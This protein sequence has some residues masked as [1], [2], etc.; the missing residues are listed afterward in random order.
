MSV[1][2]R[3]VA[4]TG[5]QAVVIVVVKIV[6][7]AGLRVGQIGKNRPLAGFEHLGFEPRPETFRLVRTR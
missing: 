7:D 2:R 5:V 3:L 4:N 1:I 6:G